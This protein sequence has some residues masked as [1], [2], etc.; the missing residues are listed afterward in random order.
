MTQ[1]GNL[2]ITITIDN[3]DLSK[4]ELQ[5]ETQ[6]LLE[7]IED[8]EIVETAD[9]VTIDKAMPYHFGQFLLTAQSLGVLIVSK[10]LEIE[11]FVRE[12]QK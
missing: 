5:E 3:S 2:K 8:S 9:M 11:I 7:Q 12:L 4:K 1:Q 6:N 10:R